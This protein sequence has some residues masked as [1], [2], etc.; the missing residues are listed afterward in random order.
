[1]NRALYFLLPLLVMFT[2]HYL[3]A[4]AYA[5]VCAPLSLRGFLYAIFTT[6]SPVC[7]AL[8][9]VLNYASTNY[10]L[11][12]SGLLASGIGLLTTVFGSKSTAATVA[13][14]QEAPA[15]AAAPAPA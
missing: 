14:R 5:A 7:S 12:I 15:P 13:T 4:N 9:G 6:S 10:G 2:G 3:A 11:I 8:L 1:M